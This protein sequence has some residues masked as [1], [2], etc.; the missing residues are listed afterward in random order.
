MGWLK[1][2]FQTEHHKQT[3]KQSKLTEY[4]ECYVR[5]E[6]RIND[7]WHQMHM[8]YTQW[9]VWKMPDAA[10]RLIR[11]CKNKKTNN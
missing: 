9:M 1:A 2:P 10:V 8:N 4:S 6:T 7:S 3:N 11:H 5:C